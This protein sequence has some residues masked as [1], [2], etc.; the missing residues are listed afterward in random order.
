MPRDLRSRVSELEPELI[1]L[2][3]DFHQHPELG[4]EEHRTSGIIEDYLKDLGLEVSRMGETGVIGLLRGGQPGKTLMMRADID[5]LP[6]VEDTGLEHAS[7]VHGKMHACGHDG[8]TAMMMVAAKVL[9]EQRDDLKGDIKFVFQPNEEL[10]FAA[11]MVEAGVLH[12]PT[13]DA[14]IGT[15]LMTDLPTG[16]L[17][18]QD[19]AVMAEA[20]VF[21]LT[22]KGRGGHTAIPDDAVDPISAA[23]AVVQQAQLLLAREISPHRACAIVF[24]SIH[25]GS[26]ANIIPEQAELTGTV[27]CLFES[28][29]DKGET[30]LERFERIV[31]NVCAAHRVDVEI[32]WTAFDPPTVN[33]PLLTA[34]MREAAATVIAGTDRQ[35]VPYV[36]MIGE[37]F[38]EFAMHVPGTFYFIGVGNPDKG[39]DWPHHHPK[40]D[41]DE[42]ALAIG[43]EMHVSG[44]L[45]YLDSQLSNETR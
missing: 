4:L 33:D 6:I 11:N 2:R 35:L 26:A 30:V 44:A 15:H 39:T 22:L 8:H 1:A 21:K 19:G 41:I 7:K 10:G 23:A 13:V 17:S 34:T 3:R 37:D 24:G 12:N 18:A 28:R 29:A 27:R 9:A 31:R 42:D 43:V 40:F 16:S 25:S 45:A 32:E 38:G 36:T 14:V 5:A 20:N